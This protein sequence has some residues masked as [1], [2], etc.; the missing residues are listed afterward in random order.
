MAVIYLEFHAFAREDRNL[1]PSEAAERRGD[2][3]RTGSLMSFTFSNH[4]SRP[5]VTWRPSRPA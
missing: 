1:V 3:G 4:D 5:S 2:H